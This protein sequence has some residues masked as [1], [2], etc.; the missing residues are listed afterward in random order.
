M[1]YPDFQIQLMQWP[2]WLSIKH[3][4]FQILIIVSQY[5]ISV[6]SKILYVMFLTLKRMSRGQSDFGVPVFLMYRP[7]SEFQKCTPPIYQLDMMNFCKMPQNTAKCPEN[8]AATPHF[9]ES[10][11]CHCFG[12]IMICVNANIVALLILAWFICISSIIDKKNCWLLHPW[13]DSG[14][15]PIVPRGR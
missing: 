3:L 15:Y 5:G 11:I 14:S 7:F 2:E 4:S 1:A 13:T 8:V 10:W 6:G 9:Q 12:I